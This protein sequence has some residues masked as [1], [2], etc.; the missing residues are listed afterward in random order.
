[1]AVTKSKT[2]GMRPDITVTTSC[3]TS[4]YEGHRAGSPL[5]V[6]DEL[7][8]SS[9]AIS[10]GM[11]RA[12]RVT[13]SHLVQG[14]ASANNPILPSL[15]LSYLVLFVVTGGDARAEVAAHCPRAP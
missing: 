1:M 12:L 14:K 9:V 10:S 8:C 3:S 6:F 2:N 7:A 5:L 15:H 11:F 4:C 13:S